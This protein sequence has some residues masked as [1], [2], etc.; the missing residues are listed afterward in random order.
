M[1]DYE[2][3][4]NYMK[5]LKRQRQIFEVM[6]GALNGNTINEELEIMQDIIDILEKNRL[7]HIEDRGNA[8]ERP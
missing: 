7:Q 3:L 4:I 6:I 8:G 1:K 2:K 5:T